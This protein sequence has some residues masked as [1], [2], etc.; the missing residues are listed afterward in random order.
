MTPLPRAVRAALFARSFA[1]QGSWNYRTL[2]G[3][4]FAFTLAPALRLKGPAAAEEALRRHAGLFN[5]HPYLAPMAI[6]AVARMEAD[7][8]DPALIER[9]KA[10]VRGSLGTLGDRLVW[11]GWRPFCLIAAITLVLVGVSGV[12]AVVAFLALYNAGH[13]W[14]RWWSLR[15]G[16]A[17]G[18]RVGERLRRSP[19]PDLQRGLT[20]GGAFLL[21]LMLPLVASG[22]LLRVQTGT[23]WTLVAA[24]AAAAGVR[25]GSVVR[26]PVIVALIA[27][28]VL[29]TALGLTR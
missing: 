8:E 23:I 11:A 4:G 10:A 29:G 28:A 21:G 2:I 24:A 16:L 26:A 5:C 7:G 12:L 6:G 3:A 19:L 13:V 20:L 14:L 17:E 9:F 1:V 15:I 27:V 25:W 22:A 18:K